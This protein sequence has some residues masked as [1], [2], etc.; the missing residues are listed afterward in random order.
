MGT[1]SDVSS[2]VRVGRGTR[3]ASLASIVSRLTYPWL[4]YPVL[5][6]LILQAWN[7]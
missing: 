1:R 6:S 3:I 5:T 2:D 7:V 4:Q